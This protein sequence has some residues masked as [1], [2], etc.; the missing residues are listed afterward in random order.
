M[1]VIINDGNC[2]YQV[3]TQMFLETDTNRVK[4]LHRRSC[5]CTFYLSV[6]LKIWFVAANIMY[7]VLSH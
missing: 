6:P 3:S 4:L 5:I 7:K 1:K 2:L